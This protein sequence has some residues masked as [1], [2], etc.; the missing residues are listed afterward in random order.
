MFG[1]KNSYT[2]STTKMISELYCSINRDDE[3][4]RKNKKKRGKYPKRVRK[5]FTA[6]SRESMARSTTVE[7]T[8]SRAPPKSMY[9]EASSCFA[10]YSM[11]FRCLL[12]TETS[13]AQ[14]S[15]TSGGTHAAQ[16]A[17]AT[18]CPSI[19]G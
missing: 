18:S 10:P 12:H 3:M 7:K 8:K 9:T 15:Q 14:M 17:S 1:L 16:E 2:V 11:V 5:R 19:R 13:V 4:Q 6:R